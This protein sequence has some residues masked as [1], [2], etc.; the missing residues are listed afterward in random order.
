[1]TYPTSDLD[2]IT[3]E[4]VRLLRS[5]GIRT[6]VKLL[7]AAC[8]VPKRKSLAAKTGIPEQQLLSWANNADRMRIKG[9]GQDCSKALQA[10][11]VRTVRS[12]KYRNPKHLAEAIRSLNGRQKLMRQPPTEKAIKRWIEAARKLDQKIK[13]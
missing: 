7:D 8:T 2:G 4:Q 5:A 12:L 1:M 11:G 3:H 9:I 10:I 6:T 13:Y